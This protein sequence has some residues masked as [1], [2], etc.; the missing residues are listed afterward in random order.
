MTK[1]I[2][3]PQRS[4]AVRI[5]SRRSLSCSG[6][7][8]RL[9]CTRAMSC[10]APLQW[11]ASRCVRIRPS[12]D[13]SPPMRSSRAAVSPTA[14]PPSPPQSTTNVAPPPRRTVHAPCP[15]SSAVMETGSV[16][17]RAAPRIA[18][19]SVTARQAANTPGCLR[20]WSRKI[21]NIPVAA[22]SQTHRSVRLR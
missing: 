16:S 8:S 4:A 3:V 9:T 21:T 22:M 20:R 6:R 14:S 7:N 19:V 13:V 12:M 17:H 18:A 15:T 10:A 11:S 5:A 2:S 1:T